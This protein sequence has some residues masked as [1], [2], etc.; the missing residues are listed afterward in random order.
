MTT[1]FTLADIEADA[2]A[3]AH[4][5]IADGVDLWTTQIQRSR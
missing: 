4:K 2:Q 3:A 1:R 5:A